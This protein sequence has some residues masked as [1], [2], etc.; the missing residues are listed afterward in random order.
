MAT[1]TTDPSAARMRD[2]VTRGGT[3]AATL[4]VAGWSIRSGEAAGGEPAGVA[5]AG[6]AGGAGGDELH[7]AAAQRPASTLIWRA[8]R[9]SALCGSGAH[10]LKDAD[11]P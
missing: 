11:L 5:G 10:P 3:W 4:A 7:A 8:M 2:T 9:V 1:V 6:A